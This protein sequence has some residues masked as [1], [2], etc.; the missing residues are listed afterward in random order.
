MQEK[1]YYSCKVWGF[2]KYYHSEVSVCNVNW[3]SVL[4]STLPTI[5]SAT[6]FN[7]F[8]D[9][10]DTML[11]AAGPM[12]ISS[13][14]FPDTIPIERK[15]NRD[16][17]WVSSPMLRTDVRIQLD[18]IKNNFRPHPICWVKNN[19]FTSSY[20][21]YLVFPYDSLGLN[22]NTAT[23]FP[24]QNHRLL[25]FFKY[26]N[27]IRYFYPYNYVLDT[28]CDTTL[29]HYARRIANCPD[30]PS[31]FSLYLQIAQ[32][33]NDAHV[34]AY[35]YSTNYTIPPG[36]SLPYL[37]LKFVEGKY[38]VIKSNEPNIYPGDVII[39]VDGRTPTQWED[40]LNKFYS[41]GNLSVFHRSMCDRM[42]RRNIIGTNELVV[43][44]DSLGVN[45]TYN[46][47]TV[48]PTI[49]PTFFYSY[50]Y[51]VDSIG[52]LQW[53]TLPCDIGYVNMGNL[54]P[55]NVNTMYSELKHKSAIIFDLRN[56][57]QG[58]AWPI[59]NLMFPNKLQFSK[60][61]N[62]DVT[63]PGTYKWYNDYLGVNGNPTPYTGKIA[64][65]IDEQTQSQAE[66]SCMILEAMPNVIKIG[67]QTA[68][69]D[70]DV[71]YWKVS[72]D[73]RTG[74]SS[75]GIFYPNGDSTQ[76]IGI[77]PD[78]VISPTRV[79]IRHKKDL[80]LEKA[81][82]ALECNLGISYMTSTPFIDIH[83]NPTNN[84][85]IIESDMGSDNIDVEIYLSDLLGRHILQKRCLVTQGQLREKLS[86]EHLSSGLYLLEIKTQ[87]DLLL[88]KIIKQ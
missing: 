23:S 87:N 15:R 86:I 61:L 5:F 64:I 14:Y 52:T 85:L 46:V 72:Q 68:G 62:P 34:Y 70:G 81:L 18:T 9:A 75:A 63:Y 74:M 71:T 45:H 67:S 36:A 53:T 78:T 26:W 43:V 47:T 88:Y 40:S 49:N 16:W 82:K 66:Y 79:A 65:L 13:S 48:S 1:L 69:A 2:V 56:Y 38:V 31:L 35:T 28:T 22:V 76:R 39:S 32:S 24:D 51:P 50:Y 33:L 80:V 29:F 42:L 83:P 41:S 4:L 59:A 84:I 7:Q 55:S 21:G 6:T 57:P 3:D 11:A 30:A 58:T 8:N 60:N 25:M 54:S 17:S 10:L 37:R 12:V 73:I 20:N 19:T 77:V 27:I 44:E